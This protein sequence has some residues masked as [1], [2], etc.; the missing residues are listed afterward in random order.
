MH[1]DI[2]LNIDNNLDP[3]FGIA[4]S[5]TGSRIASACTKAKGAD[6]SGP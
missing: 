4:Y 2:E 5:R 6:R 1:Y 3:I